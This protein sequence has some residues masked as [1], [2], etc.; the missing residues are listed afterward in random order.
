M[1]GRGV[2]LPLDDYAILSQSQGDELDH[3]SGLVLGACE[4]RQAR[5]VLLKT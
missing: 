4:C 5:T 2:R 1:W 3:G